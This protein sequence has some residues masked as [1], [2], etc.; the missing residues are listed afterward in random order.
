MEEDSAETMDQMSTSRLSSGGIQ[1]PNRLLDAFGDLDSQKVEVPD[2]NEQH[3]KACSGMASSRWSEE[4]KG[5]E[6]H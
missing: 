3:G 2:K 4:G 5:K 6:I 1:S